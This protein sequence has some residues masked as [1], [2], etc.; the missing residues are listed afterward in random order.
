[1]S[2][3]KKLVA[4]NQL[5]AK[6]TQKIG[7]RSSS[8]REKSVENIAMVD[9][10]DRQSTNKN[11]QMRAALDDHDAPQHAMLQLSATAGPD[12]EGPIGHKLREEARNAEAKSQNCKTDAKKALN[13]DTRNKLLQESLNYASLSKQLNQKAAEAIVAHNNK[14]S[15]KSRDDFL[16]LHGLY[17]KEAV[18]E[19]KKRF[20][21]LEA[22]DF[23]TDL[24]LV[25]GAGK[26][27]RGGK[28]VLKP[29]CI[30]VVKKRGYEFSEDTGSLLES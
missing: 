23:D 19:L 16:D 21:L 27:S 17:I 8:K 22:K 13:S 26:H 4:K 25:T 24:R 29:V 1:M 2:P 12:Y 18:C 28:S 7:K 20:D 10:C 6:G 14:K 15:K 11:M 5:N 3:K 30:E 9:L